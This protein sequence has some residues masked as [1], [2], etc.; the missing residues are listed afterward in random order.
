MS[1]LSGN[2][3]TAKVDWLPRIDFLL[4]HPVQK[5]WPYILRSDKWIKTY[6][7][8][9]LSGQ[10]NAP[11]EIKRLS[12]LG[13]DGDVQGAFLVETVRVI[14]EKRL[15]YRLLPLDEPFRTT[16]KINGYEIFN[17]YELD[18]RTLVTYETVARVET[19]LVSQEEFGSQWLSADGNTMS[20]WF[21]TYIP[22]L[23]RQLEG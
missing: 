2:G 18:E 4:D 14:P 6:R 15:V 20:S 1:G 16:E 22:E 9:H 12:Q 11:G 7:F 19:T 13:D 21:E 10:H 5:V 3:S 23:Q 8:E 17:L